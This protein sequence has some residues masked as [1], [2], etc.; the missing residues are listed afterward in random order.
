[1][2]ISRLSILWRS[3]L[4]FAILAVAIAPTA[5]AQTPANDDF[6]NATVITSLPYW[7]AQNTVD[8][9]AAPT[10]PPTCP[11]YG[12]AVDGATVWYSFTAPKNMPLRADTYGSYYPDGDSYDSMLSVWTGQPGNFTQVACN[13]FYPWAHSHLTFDAVKDVTYYF[14]AGG[15][16]G[17]PGAEQ[18]GFDLNEVFEV[19]VTIDPTGSVNKGVA[20]ITGTVSCSLTNLY[21][22]LGAY[23]D[24]TLRQVRSRQ[25]LEALSGWYVYPCRDNQKRWEITAMTESGKPFASGPALVSIDV[26]G[27]DEDDFWFCTKTVT[28]SGNVLL[29]A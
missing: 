9:T 19:D 27:C 25:T 10:D 3:T 17:E 23:G 15:A 22:Y 4:L 2:K 24:V 14:M 21:K 13:D 26:T 11:D 18:L 28:V 29:K 20:T 12:S 8:A 7:D 1:M 5:F 6:A 16:R